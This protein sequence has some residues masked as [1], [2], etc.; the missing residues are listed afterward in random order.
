MRLSIISPLYKKVGG[1]KPR[2]LYLFSSCI[3]EETAHNIEK[4]FS[5]EEIR[6]AVFSKEKD[7]SLGLDGFSMLFYQE[8]WDILKEDIMKV[9]VEFYE[10]G[11]IGK[12]VNSTVLVL[13]PKKSNA[14]ELSKFLPISL[15]GSLYKIIANVLSQRLK[16]VME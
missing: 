12:G 10:N 6:Y 14:K 3:K 2:I 4:P 1:E 8:C 11:I 13:L 15:I 7:K 5:M 16:E 9:F